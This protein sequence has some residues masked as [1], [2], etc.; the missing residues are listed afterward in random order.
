MPKFSIFQK[1][2]LAVKSLFTFIKIEN[3]TKTFETDEK[4]KELLKNVRNVNKTRYYTSEIEIPFEILKKC[5][6]RYDGMT[7]NDF[8]MAIYGKSLYQYCAKKGVQ[9]P[10]GV[11]CEVPVAHKKLPT[12]YHDLSI[13][14]YMFIIN[15]ELPIVDSIKEGYDKIK[16]YVSYLLQPEIQKQCI[17]MMHI[18]PYVPKSLI[19]DEI[20]NSAS[21]LYFGISNLPFSDRPYKICGKQ[22][23]K[24][25]IFNNLI[26]SRIFCFVFTYNDKVCLTTCVNENTDVDGQMFQDLVIA[27][28][29]EQIA[30]LPKR[31]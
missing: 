7:F 20:M 21:G 10:K 22:V 24:L 12:G 8:M 27:E 29:Q 15:I 19:M 3:K 13:S 2:I 23:K 26:G 9:D 5:Y 25:R 1:L 11:R 31:D 18:V 17:N 16:P 30:F 6:K 14:D 28:I 4:T